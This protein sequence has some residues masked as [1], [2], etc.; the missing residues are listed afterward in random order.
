MTI[1]TTTPLPNGAHGNQSGDIRNVPPGYVA[2][3][4]EFDATW[5]EFAPFVELTLDDDGNITDMQDNPA[6]REAAISAE[7]SPP[8]SADEVIAALSAQLTDTQIALC[9]MFEIMLGG[10]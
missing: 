9:E 7:P 3:P 1:I 4:P 10:M 6:A 8:P 2:I 5:A